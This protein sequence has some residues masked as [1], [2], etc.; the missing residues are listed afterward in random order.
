MPA[1]RQCLFQQVKADCLGIDPKWRD[2]PDHYHCF[3]E[4][5][6]WT[7]MWSCEKYEYTEDWEERI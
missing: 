1:C 5:W 7:T 3:F 6:S 4:H 2:F